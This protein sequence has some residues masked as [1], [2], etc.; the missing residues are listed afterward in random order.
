MFSR[1]CAIQST[2]Q[3][4]LL[5]FFSEI[6]SIASLFLSL[7]LSLDFSFFL[8]FNHKFASY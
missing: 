1:V 7:S 2:N 6:C 8:S 3:S 4:I 5:F